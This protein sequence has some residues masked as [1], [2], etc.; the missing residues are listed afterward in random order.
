[1][2]T[3]ASWP[4]QWMTRERDE[5]SMQRGAP[6]A[7]WGGACGVRQVTMLDDQLVFA[8]TSDRTFH[9]RRTTW[10]TEGIWAVEVRL[11]WHR[12]ATVRVMVGAYATIGESVAQ[13]ISEAQL[14]RDVVSVVSVGSTPRILSTR[15]ATEQWHTIR[16]EAHVQSARMRW[17]MDGAVVIE[18][19]MLPA[20]SFGPYFVVAGYGPCLADVFAVGTVSIEEGM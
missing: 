1:V 11:R 3:V 15:L 19:G 10:P 2:D 9:G 4:T 5:P 6:W 13:T 18:Q 20:E 14:D 16:F 12:E 7:S 17:I 8:S